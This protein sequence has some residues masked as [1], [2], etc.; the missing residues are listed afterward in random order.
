MGLEVIFETAVFEK[1]GFSSFLLGAYFILDHQSCLSWCVHL[2][3]VAEMSSPLGIRLP[4]FCLE[5]LAK[6]RRVYLT[7]AF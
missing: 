3:V 7:L 5:S 4:L 6:R 1:G 2:V